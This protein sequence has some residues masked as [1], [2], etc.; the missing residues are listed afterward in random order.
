MNGS[1]AAT[2]SA[3]GYAAMRAGSMGSAVSA[4]YSENAGFKGPNSVQSLQAGNRSST[5]FVFQS[6]DLSPEKPQSYSADTSTS[7]L[8]A[9][10]DMGRLPGMG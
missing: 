1:H 10:S 9:R 2:S 3:Q 5:S 7:L 4:K 8:G 6:K